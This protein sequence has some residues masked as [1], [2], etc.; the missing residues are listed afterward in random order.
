MAYTV[1]GA[2][3]AVQQTQATLP[4]DQGAYIKA[5][6]TIND[7]A[8]GGS[9]QGNGSLM[10]PYYKTALLG[11]LGWVADSQ[12]WFLMQRGGAGPQFLLGLDIEPIIAIVGP[13]VVRPPAFII[14]L[15]QRLGF[16]RKRYQGHFAIYLQYQQPHFNVVLTEDQINPRLTGTISQSALS[17]GPIVPPASVEVVLDSVATAS[18]FQ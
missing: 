1:D 11:N 16:L 10:I 18:V 13:V 17:V 5:H 12:F 6:V 8:G 9:I 15:L 7:A 14:S 2:I 4:P 3:A